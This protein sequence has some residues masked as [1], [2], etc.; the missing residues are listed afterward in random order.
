MRRFSAARSILRL[1]LDL[2]ELGDAVDQPGDVL[3]EQLLDLFGRRERVLDRV[4]EDR[5]DDR[6][7]VELEVGED[8]RDL[9][10]VAEIGVARGALLGAVRL[11]REDVGAV[12]QPL[13]RIGIV[14]PDLLDQFVLSQHPPKM[15]RSGLIVQARKEGVGRRAEGEEEA[16]PGEIL[17]GGE[18]LCRLR[19]RR[20]V[21]ALELGRREVRGR[22]RGSCRRAGALGERLAQDDR[23]ALA[24]SRPG[25]RAGPQFQMMSRAMKR[26][27]GRRCQRR[28][29]SRAAARARQQSR[30]PRG[31]EAERSIAV[32]PVIKLRFE[33]E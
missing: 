4:V 18:R 1:R 17:L 30:R 6:L 29:I 31:S 3:A 32:P 28:R 23:T 22:R 15:G 13:V 19:L 16:A 27:D 11:H 10:R 2:A 5:G 26:L 20:G 8:A 7:V 14:G 12:D 9:D 24:R 25:R 21:A 33:T